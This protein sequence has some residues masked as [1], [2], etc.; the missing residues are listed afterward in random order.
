[1]KALAPHSALLDVSTDVWHANALAPSVLQ[2]IATG[3]A[4]LDAQLPGGGW[5][6]GAMTEVLQSAGLHAE[7]RL[8]LSALARLGQDKVVLVN[9]P[10]V[11]FAPSLAA[12]GLQAH[13]LLWIRSQ[14]G[15]ESLWSAEQALRCAQVDAVLAWLPQVRT[16][17]LR[18]L[19]LAAT[20]FN[21]LLFVVRPLQ[22]QSESSPAVLR[23]MV[24]PGPTPSALNVHLLKRRGPPR[25]EPLTLS[26]S[27]GALATLLASCH[28]EQAS[29]LSP[30][31][32]LDRIAA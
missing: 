13:R 10:Q 12:A 18:R 9:A 19:Q 3:D 27:A 20:D 6:V 21:K 24:T 2:V 22:A 31:H 15:A 14:S 29:P 26:M 11:P 30:R 32:A 17:H 16:E 7:W 5:P 25:A 8:V 1:M 4:V 23:V 28:R